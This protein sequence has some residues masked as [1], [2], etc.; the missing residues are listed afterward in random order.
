MVFT[1]RTIRAGLRSVIRRNRIGD[2]PIYLQIEPSS[3]CNYDCLMCV[4][5][6][7]IPDPKN[8]SLEY[9]INII[10]RIKPYLVTLSGYGEPLLNPQFFDMVRFLK[11]S[12]IA[13][14]TVTNG[15]LLDRF[16]LDAIDSGIDQINISIDAATDTTYR[17]IRRNDNFQRVIENIRI[18]SAKKGKAHNVPE[19]KGSFVIQKDNQNEIVPFVHLAREIGLD[20]VMF[21]P[22]MNPAIDNSKNHIAQI[23]SKDKIVTMLN[24]ADSLSRQLNIKTN[25]TQLIRNID[26]YL[27]VQYQLMPRPS[28]L[29]QCIKPYY[30]AYISADGFVRPCC[31]F[32][33]LPVDMGNIF[34]DDILD[35][36]NSDK[37]ITFRNM[38]KHGKSPHLACDRCVPLSLRETI[39]VI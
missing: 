31:T 2:A 38:L 19:L 18:L 37:F 9:F 28:L 4:R 25:L 29:K 22:Y 30:S 15:F 35:I 36:M 5:K 14:N 10:N 6:T 3:F 20:S 1:I 27:S 23:A 8:M 11:K 26:H 16:T 39:E 21:Q 34:N 7:A 24:A 13:V 17:I 32:A 12:D 33:S